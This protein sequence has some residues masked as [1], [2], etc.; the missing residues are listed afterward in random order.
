LEETPGGGAERHTGARDALG[1]IF[2]VDYVQFMLS[3][4]GGH[5]ESDEIGIEIA[6]DARG[7]QIAIVM[8]RTASPRRTSS[9]RAT[10]S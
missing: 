3:S 8:V 2:P 10:R 6:F 7:D 5:G 1:I 9:G 4:N